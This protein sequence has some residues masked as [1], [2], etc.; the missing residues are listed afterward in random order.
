[1]GTFVE[2][3]AHVKIIK[4]SKEKIVEFEIIE[5]N[6]QYATMYMEQI[7]TYA[8]GLEKMCGAKTNV[9]GNTIT[10]VFD[11]EEIASRIRNDWEMNL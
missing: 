2:A 7:I 4:P 3:M 10:I 9:N 11:D 6:N 8:K 5:P 1:M